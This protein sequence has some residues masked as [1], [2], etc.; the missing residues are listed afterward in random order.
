MVPG[1]LLFGILFIL[2]LV[3]MLRSSEIRDNSSWLFYFCSPPPQDLKYPGLAWNALEPL[4]L[5]P[6]TLVLELQTCANLLLGVLSTRYSPESPG[7]R[8]PQLKA[9]LD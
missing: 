9:F 1:A 4:A 8:E 2:Y 5:S 7:K 3:F 6:S